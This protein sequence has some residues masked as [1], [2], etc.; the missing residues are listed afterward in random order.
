MVGQA[1]C[2][3][4]VDGLL[5]PFQGLKS[6]DLLE[7]KPSPGASQPHPSQFLKGSDEIRQISDG[8]S[9]QHQVEIQAIPRPAGILFL[10]GWL[11]DERWGDT[12]IV[13]QNLCIARGC[14]LEDIGI[15]AGAYQQATLAGCG[16][17]AE[18]DDLSEGLSESATEGAALIW[19]QVQG[20]PGLQGKME[21]GDPQPF[22]GGAGLSRFHP[23]LVR[24]IFPTAFSSAPF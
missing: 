17:L 23:V 13:M 6:A 12:G 15:R 19:G 7:E 4:W 8:A 14:R 21:F 11:D 24:S 3:A 18:T 16:F 2:S 20:I 1:P 5:A 10:Q 9:D 22:R